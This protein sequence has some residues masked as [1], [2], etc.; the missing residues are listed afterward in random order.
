MVN[1]LQTGWLSNWNLVSVIDKEP[2]QYTELEMKISIH[3]NDLK[4][5]TYLNYHQIL[6]DYFL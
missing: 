2:C 4:K 1:N 5:N 6:L 3:Q